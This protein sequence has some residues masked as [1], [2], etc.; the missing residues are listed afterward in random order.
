[1]NVPNVILILTLK[2]HNLNEYIYAISISNF[3]LYFPLTKSQIN[4]FLL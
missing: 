2:F 4:K 3:L 1:M